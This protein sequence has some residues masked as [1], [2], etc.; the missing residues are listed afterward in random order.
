MRLYISPVCLE[1]FL[2]TINRQLLGD[3]DIF[4]AAII[5]FAGITFGIFVGEDSSLGFKHTRTGIVLGGNQ[6][7]MLFLTF[8]L[9]FNSFPQGIIKPLNLHCLFVHKYSL[10]GIIF[11]MPGSPLM[12]N[13]DTAGTDSL[14]G[15]AGLN[16]CTGYQIPPVNALLFRLS[17]NRLS[18]RRTSW[19]GSPQLVLADFITGCFISINML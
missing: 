8:L 14:G 17:G 6:F 4:T 7:N 15:T 5:T 1:Q 2:G 11:K 9:T 18:G 10:F 3:I 12:L 16:T 19:R 13:Q